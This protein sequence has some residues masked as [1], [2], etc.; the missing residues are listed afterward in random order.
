[1]EEEL[2]K[3]EQPTTGRG[4]V[5]VLL[6]GPKA[7]DRLVVGTAKGVI[8]IIS[9]GLANTLASVDKSFKNLYGDILK[10]TVNFGL[11]IFG[12]SIK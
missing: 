4:L 8:S 7:V 1:M 12:L 5:G 10:N 3:E 9:P 6:V 2:P 11:G